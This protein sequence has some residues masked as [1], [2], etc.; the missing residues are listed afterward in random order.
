[1]S[2]TINLTMSAHA[3][4]SDIDGE[5][6]SNNHASTTVT[7]PGVMSAII[8]Y[9]YF[10]AK[11]STNKLDAAQKM[12]SVLGGTLSF[13]AGVTDQWATIA[14]VIAGSLIKEF[15][16]ETVT[17]RTYG[18][19][20][21]EC[22]RV[23]AGSGQKGI[24]I[25]RYDAE[26]V[27]KY[28]AM[29]TGESD[30]TVTPKSFKI[31]LGDD[32][33]V[34]KIEALKING[35]KK[36][37]AVYCTEPNEIE[38]ETKNSSFSVAEPQLT[39]VKFRYRAKGAAEYTE[40]NLGTA[41]TYTLEGNE[42]P[43][44]IRL[45]G[46]MEVQAAIEDDHGGADTTPWEDVVVSAQVFAFFDYPGEG[47]FVNRF[48][49][50]LFG[51]RV[52]K[53]ITLK[54]FRYR[55]K[56]AED[57][58]EADL[59]DDFGYIMPANTITDGA[60]YEY[61]WTAT[62][63]Y[64]ATWESKWIGFTTVDMSST[65]R[66]LYPVGSLIDS[67]EA[68]MFR[69]AH[70]ISTGSEQTKADL[71][72]SADGE[73]WTDLVTVTGAETSAMIAANTFT[74][75]TWYWRVRT[76]NADGAAGEWSKAGQFIAIATPSTPIITI[77]DT[78][79]KPTIKW[80]TNEQTAYEISL[81]GESERYYGTDKTWTSTAYLP[82]GEHTVAVRVQNEY[83]RWSRVSSVV[84]NV[85]NVSGAEITLT[86]DEGELWWKTDGD[87]DHYLIYRDLEAVG[88][89]T[90]K[91]FTDALANG[92][93]RYQIRGCYNDSNNY[94]LSNTAAVTVE[95][96]YY[97]IYDME[98]GTVLTVR[99]CGLENQQITRTNSRGVTLTHVPGYAHPVAERSEFYDE[100]I[101]GAA[102]FFDA[103]DVKAFESLAG[104]L[105]CVLTPQGSN[106]IGILN[107]VEITAQGVR[108]D[109]S[110]KLTRVS[111]VASYAATA[112]ASF[113]IDLESG[114]LIMTSSDNYDGPQFR[115]T[116]AGHLGVTW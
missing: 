40:I 94:G 7:Q 8:G 100:A 67:D 36:D 99:Y 51:C 25:N 80:Q 29:F 27:V 75:G 47:A 112:S 13:S 106:Y 98:N 57:Y 46:E 21:R 28:G 35:D 91:N 14:D 44:D 76:Y 88:R 48:K 87:Y 105:V 108:T 5:W 32:I 60:E 68:A 78:S 3:I 63:R 79:P 66:P 4:I 70:I 58:T 41:T 62:D 31:T 52:H 45:S 73:T 113:E 23:K 109:A 69:W 53:G 34:K 56:G 24:E 42:I 49:V 2:E 12:K 104:R 19:S 77:A 26:R 89:T 103:G 6:D 16:P 102:V 15:D 50:A 86:A 37:I 9:R 90:V 82:D 11:Y 72:K 84:L 59:N 107:N 111:A 92:G 54:K 30:T 81:D 115:L 114:H 83:G 43:A 22:G 101:D 39:S 33:T 85:V 1:M 18:A 110:F 61:S 65:A 93:V 17:Y 38:I 74:S 95:H 97:E 20:Y 116:D 55:K 10:L 64:N 96:K 71:Q